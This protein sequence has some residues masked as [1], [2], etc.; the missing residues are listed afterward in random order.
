MKKFFKEYSYNIFRLFLNQF[1]IAL[2][3]IALAFACGRAENMTLRL[4]TSIFAVL[5]YLFL[6][7]ASMWEVGAKDGIRARA[8]GE[9]YCLWRGFV[10]SLCANGLNI[11]LAL[12][13]LPGA[14][15]D[16]AV[17]GFSS[18]CQLIALLLEGM[19][20][21]LLATPVMGAPLNTYPWMYFVIVLP[22]VLV[23]GGAYILGLHDWHA[24]NILIPKNKD[25]KN[26]GRPERKKNK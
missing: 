22:A 5:F 7:Y 26:N 25:V 21:G 18:A 20:L 12:C 4:W 10:M 6:L 13:I 1:A 2:F 9:K 3:G 11:L 14:F 24:T 16:G 19:Y 8:R 17:K 15:V 23:T